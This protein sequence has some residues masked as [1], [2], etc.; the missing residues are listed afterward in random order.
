MFKRVNGIYQHCNSAHLHQYLSEF[1]F[2]YNHRV[3][4][5]VNDEQ[6]ADR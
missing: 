1:D 4:L 5:E 6:R 3:A 2:Q